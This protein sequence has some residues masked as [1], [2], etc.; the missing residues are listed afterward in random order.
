MMRGRRR[1]L[2]FV[3]GILVLVGIVAAIASP[4]AAL[5]ALQLT[6]LALFSTSRM[7]AAYLIG[8]V[9]AIAYGHTAATS[10]R[11]ALIMLPILDVLQSIPILAFFPA[12]LLFFVVTFQGS[13]VGI[14]IAVVFLI[15]TSMAWNMAFGV[16]ES[17]TTIPQDLEAAASSFGLTKWLRF[18]L[19][20]FPAAVPKLVYNSIL[21]WT[22]GWFFLVASEIFSGNGAEFQRPGLG[23][24]IAIAGRNGDV[25]SIAIGLA[26]LAAIVLALDVFVWRPLSVW[27]ER[28]RIDAVAREGA[29]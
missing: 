21:S 9:F 1:A 5:N 25:P 19:L 17:L 15:F 27:S 14:E 24:F 4:Q 22:N 23:A 11:A 2:R 20:E 13:P 12:A 6:L 7:V 28:F 10:R 29:K 26:V 8:L 18:R 3:A 16:Y